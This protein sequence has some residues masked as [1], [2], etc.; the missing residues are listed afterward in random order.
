MDT[1]R[2]NNLEDGFY[3]KKDW[4]ALTLPVYPQ[5]STEDGSRLYCCLSEA[6]PLSVERRM[7]KPTWLWI[8][9]GPVAQSL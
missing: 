6:T 1:R 4:R 2:A 9:G 5:V 7:S 8:G 3:V